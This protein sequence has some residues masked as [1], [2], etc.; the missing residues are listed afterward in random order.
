M[1]QSMSQSERRTLSSKLVGTD[2]C[3]TGALRLEE[4]LAEGAW[5]KVAVELADGRLAS[6]KLVEGARPAAVE[7]L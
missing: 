4:M 1:A 7:T 5:V 6:P 3:T 2:S